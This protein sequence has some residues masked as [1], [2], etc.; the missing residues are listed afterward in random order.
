[1]LK[2]TLLTVIFALCVAL[3]GAAIAGPIADFET[4]LR[5]AYADYRAALWAPRKISSPS[6][7]ESDSL[8]IRGVAAGRGGDDE[9]ARLLRR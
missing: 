9:P 1:M 2:R 6:P 7:Y 3:P 8:I 4:A 5:A